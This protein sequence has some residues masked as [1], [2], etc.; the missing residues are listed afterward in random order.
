MAKLDF[1]ITVNLNRYTGTDAHVVIP[2]GVTVIEWADFVKELIP[3]EYL[4]IR[5]SLLE[6]S[7]RSFAVTAHGTKYEKISE[8]LK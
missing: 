4:D 5:I 7:K 6:D 2:D 1:D 3:E 8:V